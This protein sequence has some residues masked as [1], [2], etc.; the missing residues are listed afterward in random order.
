MTT[1]GD[2]A[3]AFLYEARASGA[4]PDAD[5]VFAEAERLQAEGEREDA[6]LLYRFAARRGQIQ[7]AM[8]LGTQADPAY[9][10]TADGYLPDPE[11]AQA[12]KWY[13]MAEAAG[14]EA[15]AQRLADLQQ[16]VQQDAAAG[17]D[18]ARRLLLQWR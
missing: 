16:R 14:E 3:R 4:Q 15:A 9:H 1:G 17:D 13:T 11:P 2:K 18:Q 8:V 7:A 12:Y 10:D 6:Y 5:S